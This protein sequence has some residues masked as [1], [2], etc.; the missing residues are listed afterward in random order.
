MSNI[1]QYLKSIDPLGVKYKNTNLTYR[2]ILQNETKRLKN[3]L[4][5]EIDDYYT[6]YSPKVYKRGQHGG[7]LR[8]SL[9]ADEVCDVSANGKKLT[10]S[11]KINENAIHESII[12][13]SEAN[14]F[15]L[16][17]DGWKVKK[18]VWFKDIYRFGYYEGAHFVEDAVEEFKKTSKY[19]I[20]VE[21][22]RPL[23]YYDK[24]YNGDY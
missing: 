5:R 19:G 17:N 14:A 1:A 6:T 8:R 7:N 22:I 9:S 16:I 3:I 21:V 13:G 18:D 20:K 4:Q 10:M 2:Q 23:L 24:E 11:I 12:D 15:W